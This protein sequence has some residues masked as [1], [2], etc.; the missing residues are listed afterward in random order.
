MS[1]K[2][3][4]PLKFNLRICK[5]E[6]PTILT[7]YVS[8]LMKRKSRCENENKNF[9]LLKPWNADIEHNAA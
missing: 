8:D 7:F 6:M 3:L 2:K 1:G 9:Y 5:M 4:S